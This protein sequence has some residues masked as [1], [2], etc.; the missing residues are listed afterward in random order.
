MSVSTKLE[1]QGMHCDGCVRRVKKVMEQA[2]VTPTVVEVGRAEVDV[3]DVLLGDLL[4]RLEA[5]GYA[6]SRAG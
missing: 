6:A 3:D 1:I 5:A 4:R 2:G